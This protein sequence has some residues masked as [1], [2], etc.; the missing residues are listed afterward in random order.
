[1]DLAKA[2]IESTKK[3]PSK[4]QRKFVKLLKELGYIKERSE[5]D[6]NYNCITLGIRGSKKSTT[7][8]LSL[9]YSMVD[10]PQDDEYFKS[11]LIIA[12]DYTDL[13]DTFEKLGSL[14][15]EINQKSKEKY[16]TTMF[17][18][19][20]YKEY[21]YGYINN[22]KFTFMSDRKD[23]KYFRGINF[24]QFTDIYVDEFEYLRGLK[25]KDSIIDVMISINVFKG[26][27]TPV[28]H[29][30]GTDDGIASFGMSSLF[31]KN[32]I[33]MI[34]DVRPSDFLNTIPDGIKFK[35]PS[36]FKSLLEKFI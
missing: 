12:K 25:E 19:A 35:Q 23:T 9:L 33:P 29:F 31:K 13:R 15:K 10:D 16:K 26:D 24:K 34:F 14:I 28:L 27:K 18:F 32:D 6:K 11:A 21:G 2:Y 30:Y 8:L 4:K 1:M 17:V 7:M 22:H 36:Y 20:D 3:I 5:V